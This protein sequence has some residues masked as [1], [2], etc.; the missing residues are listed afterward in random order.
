MIKRRLGFAGIL[1]V[2]LILVLYLTGGERFL[3]DSVCQGVRSSGKSR[4]K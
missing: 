4:K 2:G 3:E 1:L